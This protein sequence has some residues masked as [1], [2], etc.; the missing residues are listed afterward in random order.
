MRVDKGSNKSIQH[1]LN[2]KLMCG[3]VVIFF[4]AGAVTAL[5]RWP[6]APPK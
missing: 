2:L 5:L 1:V 4:P 6:T 3:I